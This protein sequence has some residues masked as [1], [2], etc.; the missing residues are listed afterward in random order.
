MEKLNTNLDGTYWDERYQQENTGWD[1]GYANNALVEYALTSVPKDARILIPG[2]GH[3]YELEALWKAGYQNVFAMDLSP[4]AKANFMKRVTDFPDEHYSL[5]DFFESDQ[6]FDVVLEQTF[7]CAINPNLRSTYVQH[8][9]RILNE[10]GVIA[11]VLFNFEK[12][13]GPPFGGSIAEYQ[14]LFG[15]LFQ[16]K[17]ME[18]CRNSIQPRQGNELFIE[19]IKK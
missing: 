15:E 2:A 13:I 18:E 3:A 10:K 5:G 8:M 1:I 11:G 9:H 4:T 14:S 12:P 6:K 16:I 17:I 7:F 19:L